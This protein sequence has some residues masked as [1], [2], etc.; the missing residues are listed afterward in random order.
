MLPVTISSIHVIDDLGK[1]LFLTKQGAF[2]AEGF[3]VKNYN[4]QLKILSLTYSRSLRK[5]IMITN[6]DL[7]FIDAITGA[8][9]SYV[10]NIE[11][12]VKDSLKC[13]EPNTVIAS[14][15]KLARGDNQMDPDFLVLLT[16][17]DS[18]VSF[19]NLKNY[20]KMQP[21]VLR[22][23]GEL[24]KEEQ[25]ERITCLRYLDF[26]GCLAVGYSNSY[27]KLFRVGAKGNTWLRKFCGG[28]DESKITCI[29][30]FE[31]LVITGAKNGTLAIWNLLNAQ[32][33]KISGPQNSSIQAVALLAADCFVAA[34]KYDDPVIYRLN[35]DSVFQ[36]CSVI[37]L[38][39]NLVDVYLTS[40]LHINH[41]G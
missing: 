31:H 33:Y 4:A 34:S 38:P 8:V 7:R 11:Y 36:A 18:S 30:A 6:K 21:V 20:Q 35:R 9:S 12:Q 17:M 24:E 15:Q 39:I 25:L 23:S 13:V 22:S 3:M 14:R 16:E 40:A 27:V 10:A 5:F 29:E 1:I 26:L 2:F 37:K 32:F 19:F 28:H 41:N